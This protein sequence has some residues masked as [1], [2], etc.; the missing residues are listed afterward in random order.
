MFQPGRADFDGSGRID[1]TDFIIFAQGFGRQAG[2]PGFDERLDLNDNGRVDFPDFTIFARF[3][4]ST[5]N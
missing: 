5:V 2:Q 3:F 1:F 4:G